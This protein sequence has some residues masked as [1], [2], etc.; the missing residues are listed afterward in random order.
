[1]KIHT[2]AGAPNPK[3]VHV[4]LA[5]KGIALERVAVDIIAGETRAEAFRAKN[6]MGGLPVLELDDGSYVSESLAIME[7]FEELH[8]DPPMIGA[9]PL[10]RLRVRELE[11]IA[12]LGVLMRVAQVLQNSHPFW[13]ALVKQ[14]QQVADNALRLL[15][16]TLKVLDKRIGEQPFV[17]GERPTIADCTLYAGL[18][19]A[20]TMGKPIDLSA[21]PNL[22]RW[23]ESFRKRPSARA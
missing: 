22:A 7:Y 10:E 5:E 11:R 19:F 6:P 23:N 2:F 3:R 17:A 9:T 13:A 18:W 12:E 4:Y 21:R 14:N 1:M 8:P 16:G 15:H 20:H